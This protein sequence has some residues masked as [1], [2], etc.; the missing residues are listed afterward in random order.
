MLLPVGIC[1]LSLKNDIEYSLWLHR[2]NMMN[3]L[4]VNWTR[5]LYIAKGSFSCLP[6]IFKCLSCCLFITQQIYGSRQPSVL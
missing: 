3:Q 2:C 6:F 4:V 1:K 5:S